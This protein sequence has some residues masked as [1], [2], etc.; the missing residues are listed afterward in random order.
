MI[1][2]YGYEDGSGIYY[3]R[4]DTKKCADCADKAC[5][6]ACPE[7]LFLT[8]LNDFD[9]EVILIRESNRN[10]LLTDCANCKAQG[11]ELCIAACPADAVSFSW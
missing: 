4:I 3:I 9:D 2:N 1:A 6:K 10:T 7:K 5:I 11:A 8:E